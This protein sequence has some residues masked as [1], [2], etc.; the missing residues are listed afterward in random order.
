MNV[1]YVFNGTEYT[2]SQRVVPLSLPWF[3]SGHQINS[4]REVQV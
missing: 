1:A 3:P 2:S 4:I